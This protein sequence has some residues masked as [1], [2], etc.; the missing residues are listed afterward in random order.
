M[1]DLKKKK[2]KS[3]REEMEQELVGTNREIPEISDGNA[4]GYTDNAKRDGIRYTYY[5][6]YMYT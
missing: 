2:K 5:T 6:T 4:F 1:W 3:E